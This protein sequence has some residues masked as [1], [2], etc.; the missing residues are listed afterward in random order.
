MNLRV[1]MTGATGFAGRHVAAALAAK[2]FA[3]RALVRDEIKAAGIKFAEPIIGTLADDGALDRLMKDADVVV[4]LAGT[5]A[6]ADRNSFLK[7]NRDGAR[8]VA[9]AALM[10]GIKRIIHVSSLAAR[11]PHLSDY[12]FSKN[13]GET[14]MAE[15]ANRFSL[16]ILRPPAIYG[17]GD[18]ATL[19]LFAQLTR[20]FAL[21]PGTREQRFSLLYAG[22][23]A[24]LIANLV[25]STWSGI[26]EV[27]D[28]KDGGYQWADLAAT[29]TSI[30]G[31]PV[32]PVFLPQRFL[33][34]LTRIARSADL[35]PPGKIQELYHSDWVCRGEQPD[36][37]DRTGLAEGFQQTLDWYR[38]EGWLR[39]GKRA[40]R[41]R[42]RRHQRALAA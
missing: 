32:K 8:K 9:D 12:A 27:H 41:N 5:I 38:E 22:D 11:E 28:G 2:G 25:G 20:R 26:A 29:A 30:H 3:V 6:A 42:S 18:R 24:R 17:P 21:I 36:L 10:A 39:G 16:A 15:H 31:R 37:P 14:V 1:A 4:H 19:P 35:P 7:T 33:S 34:G 13:A 40:D 23:F